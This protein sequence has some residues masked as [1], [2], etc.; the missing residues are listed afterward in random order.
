MRYGRR[1]DGR[2]DHAF[3]SSAGASV[4]ASAKACHEND[5][6]FLCTIKPQY[7]S[8]FSS[9]SSIFADFSYPRVTSRLIFVIFQDDGE[10]HFYTD[11]TDSRLGSKISFKSQH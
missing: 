4:S 9:L 5:D 2:C 7:S 8:L 11:L 3:R 1:L 10:D 6:S